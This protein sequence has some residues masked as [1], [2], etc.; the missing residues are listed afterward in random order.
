MET[1]IYVGAV[2]AAMVILAWTLDY[3]DEEKGD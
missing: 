1:L 3:D 2:F